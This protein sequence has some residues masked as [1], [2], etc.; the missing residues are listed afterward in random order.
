M[1]PPHYDPCTHSDIVAALHKDF[2]CEYVID[3]LAT[4]APQLDPPHG[5]EL[6]RFILQQLMQDETTTVESYRAQTYGSPIETVTAAVS[7]QKHIAEMLAHPGAVG[8]FRETL[9]KRFEE[10]IFHGGQHVLLPLPKK[11]GE[12]G[13]GELGGLTPHR[14]LEESPAR[15]FHT[16]HDAAAWIQQNWPGYDLEKVPE[17]SYAR[18][19]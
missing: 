4:V 17:V 19:Y 13:P 14:S 3:S 1:L 9:L 2:R 18:E 15:R 6:S 5:T 8:E 11:D 7:E 10:L 16:I 12:S